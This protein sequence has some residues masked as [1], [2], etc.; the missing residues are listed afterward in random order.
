MSVSAEQAK[1][2]KSTA[3]ILAQYGNTITTTFYQN[4]LR[5]HPDLNDIFS[6]PN[7][8]NGHQPRALAGALYAYVTHLDDLGALSPEIELICHKHASLSIQPSQ[9]EIVGTY[10]LAAMKQILGDACTPEI[11]E[12]WTVGYWA[13]ANVFIK[14]EEGLYASAGQWRTWQPFRI[15]RKVKESSEITSF[16]LSPVEESIKPLPSFSPGQ[17]ISIQTKV[18]ELGHLQSRQYSLSDAPN[19]DYYRISVKR[20]QGLDMDSHGAPLHPGYISNILHDEKNEGDMLEVTHPFGDFFLDPQEEGAEEMKTPV[21]LIS[22]GVGLTP[23][24]SIVNSLVQRG[25]RRPISWL[26]AARSSR[27]RAFTTHVTS[28]AE[29]NS[30]INVQLFNKIVEQDEVEGKDFH[31]QGRMDLGKLDEERDL[32]LW[33]SST[34][35]YVCG[36]EGFMVDI[37]D[38]LKSYGVA[39]DRV[40]MERFGTGG[41]PEA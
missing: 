20:E 1:V 36:P 10:L 8:L 19:P 32:C 41:I 28:L 30:N 5:E 33:N 27:V 9:Y 11:L 16:Y 13:L 31:F 29:Q 34:H 17:Y 14:R 3:P 6:T 37:E 15:A 2:L 21:I 23:M 12:A 26:H 4:M 22:A 40:H 25:S 18:P 38:K 7:Q 39:G 24:V 35:Y